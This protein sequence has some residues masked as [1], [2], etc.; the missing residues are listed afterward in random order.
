[1]RHLALHQPG[2]AMERAW[3]DNHGTLCAYAGKLVPA[4]DVDDVVQTALLKYYRRLEHRGAAPDVDQR[5]VLFRLV[6]DC[7]IDHVRRLE[8]ES[9]LLQAITGPRAAVRRWMTTHRKQ[10]D[11]EISAQ[12]HAAIE[13][14]RPSWRAAF[15]L[16]YRVGLTPYEA[17]GVLHV[18]S[19]TV[20]AN[21]T[22]ALDTMRTSL[23]AAGYTPALHGRRKAAL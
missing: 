5:V 23:I 2:L 10:E 15:I 3:Q 9:K 20:R 18:R 22:R 14:L 11:D 8:A 19:S 1:M 4:E 17:A 12:V 21:L 6:T 16:V 13:A 7:A